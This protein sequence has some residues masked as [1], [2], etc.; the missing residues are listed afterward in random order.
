MND[1]PLVVLSEDFASREGSG[2]DRSLWCAELGGGGWGCEQLQIYTCDRSNVAITA[3]SQLAITAKRSPD[4]TITSA[5]L[6]T[7]DRFDVRYGLI[8]ARIK[9][10]GGPGTWPA[11]WML[12]SDIDEVG[13]PACGEI[14]VMEHVG[15]D[16]N[17]VHGTAHAPG[18]AG[19]AGGLGRAHPAGCDLSADFHVYGVD[20]DVGR[21]T[22]LLDG[23]PY[24]RMTPAEAPGS[25]WPFCHPFFLVINLAVGGAWP[26]NNPP[27]PVLP[28]TLLV[29][30]IR[31]R[32]PPAAV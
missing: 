28:A 8:E 19:L 18:Y 7:K 22:W 14:D 16:P 15:S 13:W 32:K 17:T 27:A 29:D 3:Q 25:I 12:G 6:V 26:G 10:P 20:W 23:R 5:R 9:V 2:P 31:V 30:W 21:I 24:H 11:F 1:D 4:G